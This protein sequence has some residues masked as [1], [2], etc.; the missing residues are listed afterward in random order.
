MYGAVALD[1]LSSLRVADLR[2]VLW[3]QIFAGLEIAC[4]ADARLR[5]KVVIP[6]TAEGIMRFTTVVSTFSGEKK[7]IGLVSA[8]G[9]DAVV[10]RFEAIA[11]Q[12][13]ARMVTR[14]P[15]LQLM[16]HMAIA[17]AVAAAP[18]SVAIS[19]KAAK[20]AAAA[21]AVAPVAPVA[22]V[23]QPAPLDMWI[24]LAADLIF[25]I[26]VEALMA[27]WQRPATMAAAEKLSLEN[28]QAYL[29]KDIQEDELAV[30]AALV[31]MRRHGDFDLAY[32]AIPASA[33]APA[34]AADL[35]AHLPANLKS[36]VALFD[37][38]AAMLVPAGQ[39]FLERI[40]VNEAACTS[41]L[42]SWATAIK[43]EKVEM[44]KAVQQHV[45]ALA[46]VPPPLA[47]PAQRPAQQG[48]AHQSHMT[49][50]CC[51]RAGRPANGHLRETCEFYC[52]FGCKVVAP[53]HLYRNCP[54][55]ALG[56]PCPPHTN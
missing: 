10:K 8:V 22:P 33:R 44:K 1:E 15:D 18:G 55:P 47:P 49:C 24:K 51:E 32:K 11:S 19:A 13:L 5:G 54:N 34:F 29:R 7:L 48:Q 20:K 2:T 45:V 12:C 40:V 14:I 46:A 36:K 35:L 37:E 28:A 43:T 21:A 27:F 17:A 16:P 52:C 9:S 42:G 50:L 4:V 6:D 56:G 3:P 41:Q 38:A 26:I 30:A 39:T 31:V 25:L 23:V 53:G